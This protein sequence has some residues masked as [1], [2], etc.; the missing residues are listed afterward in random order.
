METLKTIFVTGG[1][2]NQGGAVA[3]CLLDRG[4]RVRILTRNADSERIRNLASR[5]AVIVRGDL[6]DP[7][8]YGRDLESADGVFSV[9]T[10]AN[11]VAKEIRQGTGLV[12][13]ARQSGIRHFLYSSV[14]GADRKTGI[15][16]FESKFIIENRIRESGLSYTIIRPSSFYENFLLPQVRSRI[17]KGTLATPMNGDSIG[18]F[19]SAGDIGDISAEIFRNPDMFAGRTLTMAREQMSMLQMAGAFSEVLGIK[20]KYQKI[21]PLLTRLIMGKNLSRM[22][23]WVNHHDAVFL[24]DLEAFRKEFPGLQ[25]GSVNGSAH[26][27]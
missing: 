3:Q 25:G 2:G 4:F 21:H 14:A 15:P 8:S 19:M 11:G 10:F 5:K 27:F 16:Q 22:F 7:N 12:E 6:N 26:I 20:I 24:G 18:Q 17:L 23:D 13:M 9:Q 1:S